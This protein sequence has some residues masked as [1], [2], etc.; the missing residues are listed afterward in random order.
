VPALETLL[1]AEQDAVYKQAAVATSGLVGVLRE[2]HLLQLLLPLA[3]LLSPSKAAVA[4][5]SA[6]TA[7]LRIIGMAKPRVADNW[8]R[9]MCW[10]AFYLSLIWDKVSMGLLELQSAMRYLP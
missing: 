10:A 9:L 8:R 6:A 4:T 5:A 1:A 2:H 7:M 3:G